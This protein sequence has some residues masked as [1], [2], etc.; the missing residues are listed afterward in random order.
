MREQLPQHDQ[1]EKAIRPAEHDS[2]V[3]A[4]TSRQAQV[5]QLQRQRGNAYVRRMLDVQRQDEGA[6]AD[7]AAPAKISSGGAEVTVEGGVAKISAPMLT[8]DAAMANFSGIIRS[9]TLQTDSV[10]ASSYTPGA[11]NLM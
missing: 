3:G 6:P 9:N 10:I 11:G 7:A 2:A 4:K 1:P 5:L 8:V